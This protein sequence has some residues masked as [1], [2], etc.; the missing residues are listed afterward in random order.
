MHKYEVGEQVCC[1]NGSAD[2]DIDTKGKPYIS[3]LV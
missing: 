1:K 2:I 3:G